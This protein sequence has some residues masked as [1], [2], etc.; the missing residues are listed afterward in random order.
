MA[1][2]KLADEFLLLFDEPG[3]EGFSVFEVMLP[4]F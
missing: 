2:L 4:V 3:Y 1:R